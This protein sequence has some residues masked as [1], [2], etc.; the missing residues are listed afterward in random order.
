MVDDVL[1]SVG[2]RAFAL[3]ASGEIWA[4]HG[5]EHPFGADF[6]GLQDLLP[7]VID[8]ATARSIAAKVPTSLLREIAL[9]GTPDEVV[10]RLADYRDHG[11][12]HVAM[13]NGTLF[14]HPRLRDALVSSVPFIKVL[15][16]ARR[17]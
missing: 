10:E 8:E 7:H 9:V 15:R 12:R 11:L 5:V 3:V 13:T 16:G 14:F 4:R 17:L 1:G 2:A 6:S